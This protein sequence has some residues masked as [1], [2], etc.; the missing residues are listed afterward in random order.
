MRLGAAPGRIGERGVVVVSQ[1]RRLIAMHEPLD[2]G[3]VVGAAKAG[4]DAF[5]GLALRDRA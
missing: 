2:R 3:W 4:F 5:D 1:G